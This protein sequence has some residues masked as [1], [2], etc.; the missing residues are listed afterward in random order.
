MFLFLFKAER[1]FA[2]AMATWRP[3]WA[4]LDYP[5]DKIQKHFDEGEGRY[6][7]PIVDPIPP[8]KI[9]PLLAETVGKVSIPSLASCY[10]DCHVN[11][12]FPH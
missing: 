2:Q 11:V 6:W 8:P 3:L 10:A 7:I 5:R 12:M 1:D 9:D 4:R